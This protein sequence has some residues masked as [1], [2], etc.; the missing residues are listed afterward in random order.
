MYGGVLN[1]I[2]ADMDGGEGNDT[3][4]GHAYGDDDML[5]GDG[6][7]YMNGRGG[8]DE[9]SGGAGDDILKGGTFSKTYGT[10]VLRGG[11]GNDTLI[12][13][14]YGAQG[15]DVYGYGEFKYL[16]GDEGDDTMYGS[17]GTANEFLW[18]GSGDDLIYGGDSTAIR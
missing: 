3:M 10:D 14:V 15:G 17:F 7:D 11:E 6:N 2:G 16:Y 4:I 8:N 12:A 9:I 1:I 18:G 13:G 5:G